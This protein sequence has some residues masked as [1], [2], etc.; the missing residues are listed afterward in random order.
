MEEA[1]TD[2]QGS[3][4]NESDARVLVQQADSFSEVDRSVRVSA[5]MALPVDRRIALLADLIYELRDEGRATQAQLHELAAELRVDASKRDASRL[6]WWD[7][8]GALVAV[9][10]S[11]T[12][13]ATA[14]TGQIPMP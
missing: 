6:G 7:R 11:A 8:L 13:A 4:L 9:V 5:I 1:S 10:V 3:E 14:A 12:V 2:A